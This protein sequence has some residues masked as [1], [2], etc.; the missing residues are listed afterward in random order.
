M[1]K[2]IEPVNFNASKDLVNHLDEMFDQLTT[3]HDRIVKADIYLKSLQVQNRDE[4][5]Q[6]QIRIFLPGEDLFM[7]QTAES[8]VSAAQKL[9][10]RAKRHLSKMN[11][12]D[13]DKARQA[14][15]V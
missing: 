7:E 14:A 8:F 9:Y 2:T 12:R 10:D 5:K 13:K 4:N 15:G 6:V 3:Y 1:D 11:R